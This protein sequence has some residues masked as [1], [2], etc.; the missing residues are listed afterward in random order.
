MATNN[1]GADFDGDIEAATND[2]LDAVTFEGVEYAA[3]VGTVTRDVEI[4]GIEGPMSDISFLFVIRTVLLTANRP[5]TGKVITYGGVE[6]RIAGVETDEA[7]VALNVF[8]K[9]FT[10]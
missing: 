10:A 8:V 7:D 2:L 9:E 1:T 5:V 6:Y 3:A 4:P